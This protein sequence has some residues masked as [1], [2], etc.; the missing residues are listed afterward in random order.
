[1]QNE[2]KVNGY[3]KVEATM[4]ITEKLIRCIMKIDI[5]RVIMLKSQAIHQRI[6]NEKR[7]QCHVGEVR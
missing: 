3:I 7:G 5:G 1:M 4:V 2:I 6:S